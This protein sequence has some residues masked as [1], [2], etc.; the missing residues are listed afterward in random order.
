[1]PF[2]SE[3]QR[4]LCYLLKNKGQAGSWD[5]SEWSKETP[6]GKKLPEHVSEK[7]SA[8]LEMVKKLARCWAGYKPVPSKEPY[9]EDSCKPIAKK[10][11]TKKE[12]KAELH[13]LFAKMSEVVASPGRGSGDE[14]AT[15]INPEPYEGM[16]KAEPV[17][18]VPGKMNFNKKPN[19][20]VSPM[21][22]ARNAAAKASIRA[23]GFDPR[24]GAVKA[25]ETTPAQPAASGFKMPSISPSSALQ[26]I[27][28]T[29]MPAIK[30]VFGDTAAYERLKSQAGRPNLVNMATN[31]QN[32]VKDVG[33]SFRAIPG[34]ISE[35]ASSAYGGVRNMRVPI[36]TYMRPKLPILGTPVGP[37]SMPLSFFGD[38]AAKEVKNY[39]SQPAQP[40]AGGSPGIISRLYNGLPADVRSNA[41]SYVTNLGNTAKGAVNAAS[42]GLANQAVQY[43]AGRRSAGFA[44]PVVDFLRNNPWAKWGL[45]GLGGL[46]LYGLGKNLFGSNEEASSGNKLQTAF[47]E[48]L[49][50][51]DREQL[52][53]VRAVY[54]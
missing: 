5:C 52:R 13:S 34:A 54:Q 23:F 21:G 40:S 4:K 35:V 45:L 24:G 10:K 48:G 25:A 17:K 32:A 37:T 14:E 43:E 30:S 3:A 50:S 1:M 27:S 42:Q 29:A 49:A 16:Q 6:K 12:K 41:Q 28:D 2:K 47:H 15:A 39:M 11:D 44:L 22:A 8:D 46:G 36:P 20:P 19:K 53:K 33:D 51:P 31:V 26:G 38:L 9:S 18:K 7:K